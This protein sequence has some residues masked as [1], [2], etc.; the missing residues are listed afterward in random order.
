MA[1]YDDDK[2]MVDWEMK[3]KQGLESKAD[4]EAEG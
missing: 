3:I 1:R 2:E 4:S